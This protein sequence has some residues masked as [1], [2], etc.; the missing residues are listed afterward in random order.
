[1]CSSVGR[2]ARLSCSGEAAAPLRDGPFRDGPFR[3]GPPRDGP[4]RDVP[5]ASPVKKTGPLRVGR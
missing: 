5:L 3:D 2:R 4:P 1:M